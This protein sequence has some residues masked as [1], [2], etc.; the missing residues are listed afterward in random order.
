MLGLWIVARGIFNELIKSTLLTVVNM[1]VVVLFTVDVPQLCLVE[2][3]KFE[4]VECLAEH[5]LR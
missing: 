2:F 5:T 4:F 1:L 3:T